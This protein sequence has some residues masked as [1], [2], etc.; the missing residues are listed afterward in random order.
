MDEADRYAIERTRADRFRFMRE[1]YRRLRDSEFET[2]NM[3]DIGRSLG[4]NDERTVNVVQYLKEEDLL[5]FRAL[6]GFVGITHTGIV[7]VEKA[8]T[9]PDQ[10][11]EHFPPAATV[12]ILG[13]V[14][15]SQV[16]IASPGG[17]QVQQFSSDELAAIRM[18]VNQVENKLE[19]LRLSQ[20][21]LQQLRADIDAIKA[22]LAAPSPRTGV[23][24]EC[25]KGV[26][27]VLERGGFPSSSSAHS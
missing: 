22:Q 16:Q 9:N 4:L 25:L 15:N 24:G 6:G 7:E 1:L 2:V 17:V 18:V 20:E 12:V 8:I 21:Q 27:R 10:P 11:T 13:D 5:Q 26:R 3:F 14:S 23:I 19:E